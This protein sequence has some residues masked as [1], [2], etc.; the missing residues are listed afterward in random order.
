MAA[1]SGPT[2]LDTRENPF[3]Q[4]RRFGSLK[5]F[6]KVS[7]E[8]VLGVIYIETSLPIDIQFMNMYEFIKQIWLLQQYLLAQG[9]GGSGCDCHSEIC[10]IRNCTVCVCLFGLYFQCFFMRQLN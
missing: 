1:P 7:L 2:K 9:L 4:A 10:R 5:L 3:T 6:L 8:L